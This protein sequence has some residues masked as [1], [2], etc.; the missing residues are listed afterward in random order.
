VRHAIL[1]GDLD[2]AVEAIEHAAPA[3]WSLSYISPM[4]SLLDRLPHEKLF[5]H[6]RLFFLG[7]LTFALTARPAK[8]ERWL[9]QI[10][11][12]QAAKNPAISSKLPLADAA[13]ALQRDDTQRVI[14]L[15]EP[16]RNVSPE[17]RFL[18]YVYLAALVT[19]YASVGRYVDAYKLLD[20]NPIVPEDRMN[21]MAL[22][23]DSTRATTQLMEGNVEEAARI[24][25]ATLARSEAAYGR[26]SV[27]A[28]LC[29]AGLSVSYYELDRIDDAR[30]VLANRTGI[31]QSSMPQ[32]MIFAALSHARLDCLQESP[33]TAIAF[34]ELQAA[35]Y[36]GLGLDRPLA[37][38]L[39]EQLRILLAKGDQ[40]RAAKLASKLDELAA[41]HRDADG[42]RAEVPAI[43]AMARARLALVEVRPADAL[44]ALSAARR[45][46]QGYGR[47]RMLVLADLLSAIALDDLQRGDE[48]GEFLVRAVQSGSRFGLVRT[49]VDEGR[50]AGEVLER[51]QADPRLDAPAAQYLD[52]L[53]D[54]FRNAGHAL[55][56][57]GLADRDRP[58]N[59]GISLTPRE[60][61][62]LTL[63]SQAMSN[64]RIGLTLN[65][66][67]ETVKWNVKNILAKL[68][69]SSR[70]DAM[71]WA[72]KQGL[73]E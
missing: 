42:Y 64:K 24:G 20:D 59:Q 69:V 9:V 11:E 12:S 21:D 73:I 30:E 13:V 37:H 53:L 3:T 68:G 46:A 17:N 57:K 56:G 43:A 8:A 29:A 34:L 70:Y 15:L 25:A 47:W 4:L 54:R 48:A 22:V 71:A 2:F 36:H 60:L 62:I 33:D 28:N 35:H 41:Q 58:A 39:A 65:I 16:L 26:R 23:V 67:L 49:F 14:D 51:L 19:A 40:A 63:V 27:C 5:A 44:E 55:R 18:H 45:Q 52:A 72:R 10:R 50:R 61:E 66:T 32:V 31:L 1:G 38:M 6:P 7:C